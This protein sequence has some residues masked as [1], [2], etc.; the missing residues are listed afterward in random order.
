V[1]DIIRRYKEVIG[2]RIPLACNRS[3]LVEAMSTWFGTTGTEP[4]PAD[5][6]ELEDLLSKRRA[7][8]AAAVRIHEASRHLLQ[9]NN[10]CSEETSVSRS[11]PF[12]HD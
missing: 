6:A 1:D 8:S 5:L 12:L 4:S 3:S 7:V 10:H 2:K 9:G 11:H